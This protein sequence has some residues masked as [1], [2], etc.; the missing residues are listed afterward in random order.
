MSYY[1]RIGL[2]SLALALATAG[3]LVLGPRSA[4]VMLVARAPNGDEVAVGSAIRVT[5]SR[6]V[7]RRSAEASFRLDPPA[8]GRFF[9]EDRTLT[10][11]P[12]R[13]LAPE[14]TYTVRFGAALRDDEGRASAASIGWSFRTRGARLLAVRATSDGGSELWLVS[15]TGDQARKL[16]DAPEGISDVA[17]APDGTR[18]VYVAPRGLQRSA[19][20]LISLE[21]GETRPLVDD[22]AASAATPAW[23]PLGDFI[24]FERRALSDGQLGVPRIWLAQPD[25][26]LLGPLV[27]GDGSDIS[28]APAWSPDGNSVA[29]LDGMS[30][31]VKLYSFFTDTVRELPARSGERP[32]WLPDGSALV[33]SAAVSG[34]DGPSLR[35]QLTTTGEAP[36]TRQITD[37]NAAELGPAV[38]PGGE[39]VAF[40]RR[41]PDGPEARIW[42]VDAA[43]GPARALSA[44]GPHQ[45]TQPAWSPD[46]RSLAF[47]RSSASGPP[48]SDAVVIDVASGRETVVLDNTVQVVWA[49]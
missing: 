10:F 35:L 4:P 29:F 22:G 9:W 37:G 38:S 17:M 39:A 43:G 13:P 25:G 24:A 27:T 12:T 36:A 49:P 7:D 15:P 5:F 41:S 23:A 32:S 11:Q 47:V 20:V 40:T 34:A 19:L 33:Y 6:P 28:Y 44:D 21:S 42:L 46:G 8:P 26:T 45:D 2:L 31:A 3:L 16:L 18:A 1:A 30:Q 48:R 14:T